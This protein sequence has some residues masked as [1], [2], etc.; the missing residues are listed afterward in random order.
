M[1]GLQGS[2]TGRLAGPDALA[3]R[4]PDG[5]GVFREGRLVLEHWR[6]SIIDLSDAGRQPMQLAG[7]T[8]PVMVYN[9]EVYNFED[10]RPL[11][12]DGRYRSRTDTEVVLRLYEQRGSQF[13][14]LLNGMFALAIYDPG[15]RRVLLARDRFGIKPLYYAISGDGGLQFGSELT[16]LN[17]TFG[18]PVS[19]DTAAIRS[20]F[21]LLYI[22]GEQTPFREIRRLPA[23]HYLIF[24]LDT[25]K[26]ELH[27]YHRFTFSP[28]GQD[29]A[30]CIETVDR[31]LDES[32]RMHLVSDV[33]IGALLSGGVDSSLI[34]AKMARHAPDV[35]TFS[36]GHGN[37]SHYDESKYFNLVARQYGTHHLHTVIDQGDL[38]ALVD[39]VCDV[40]DEPLGDTSIFLNYFIFRFVSQSVKVCLSGLGGDEL[41]G[42]YNRYLACTMLPVYRAWPAAFRR[43]IGAMVRLLPSSRSSTIGNK[44]RHLK[45]FLAGA[46][47]EMGDAYCRFIDYFADGDASPL[48]DGVA[49]D[50]PRFNAYWDE[51]LLDEIGRIYK[52][53]LENYMVDDLLLLTDRMSMRH[54]V[55][56]RVPYVENRLVEFATGIAPGHKIHGTTLKYILKKVAERYVSKDV[57][58]RRKQG[59]SSPTAG[60]LDTATLDGLLQ[61]LRDDLNPFVDILNRALFIKMI[62]RQRSGRADY[63]LQIFTLIVYLRWMGRRP[64]C[65]ASAPLEVTVGRSDSI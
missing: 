33:P 35:H 38:P 39:E 16:A 18:S 24:D 61:Q 26:Y 37:T 44:L 45:A 31:L 25:Q 22:P 1:C 6:L 19:I 59:F 28:N 60:L 63:S 5:Y 29:E 55:E 8:S 62:E 23:G 12:G 15:R 40:I 20:L 64:V 7:Q 65:R 32:V 2:T 42:G 43:T 34:V 21:H 14:G 13:L 58:Y 4:G 54:S 50:H 3:H 49:F 48:A 51:E 11:T 47:A 57:I 41:F 46:D 10:L 17:A 30:A 9:G 52:Y 27:R 53:D 36:V 56:A